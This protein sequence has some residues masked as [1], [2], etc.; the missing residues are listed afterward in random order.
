MQN[1]YMSAIDTFIVVY[2][3]QG[4]EPSGTLEI[5]LLEYRDI[6]RK[7]RES[8]R[9]TKVSRHEYRC[10]DIFKITLA[11]KSFSETLTTQAFEEES[12]LSMVTFGNALNDVI[13]NPWKIKLQKIEVGYS[14]LLYIY[15]L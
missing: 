4:V 9:C 5:H 1:V 8:K 10:T 14:V 7:S 12:G 11:S 13:S 6:H 3:F 2:L 15:I